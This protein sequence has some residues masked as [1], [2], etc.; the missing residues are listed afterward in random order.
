MSKVLKV[1]DFIDRCAGPVILFVIIIDVFLQV[2]SRILPGNSISWTVELGQILLGALVWLCISEGVK[3]DA[4][5]NFDIIIKKFSK[6]TQKNMEII[7]NGLFIIY[8]VLMG[9]FTI[10]LLEYYT[11]LGS[12]S[13][14]LQINMFWVRMPILIGCILTVITLVIKNIELLAERKKQ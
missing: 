1:I 6:S 12:K 10:Q 14:I 7:N 13:T 3:T 8:L 9:T 5:V 2:L 11:R 4:H